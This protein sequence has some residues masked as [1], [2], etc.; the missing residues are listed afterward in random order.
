MTVI[1]CGNCNVT[2]KSQRLRQ[3]HCDSC[4]SVVCDSGSNSD[5][6]LLGTIENTRK[7][8]LLLHEASN[9][10]GLSKVHSQTFKNKSFGRLRMCTIK[11]QPNLVP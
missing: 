11:D 3:R 6:I 4:H 10:K 8:I 7:Y 2:G 5:S 9:R 1:I